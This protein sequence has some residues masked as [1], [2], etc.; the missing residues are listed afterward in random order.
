MTVC[1][2]VGLGS[3]QYV[4]LLVMF[5]GAFSLAHSPLITGMKGED[6]RYHELLALRTWA[7]RT[8]GCTPQYVNP[9]S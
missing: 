5:A 1:G 3:P 4:S 6:D 2:L 7:Q 8:E 9:S